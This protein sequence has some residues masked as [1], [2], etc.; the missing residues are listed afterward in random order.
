[1]INRKDPQSLVATMQS[2]YFNF[3]FFDEVVLAVLFVPT[4]APMFN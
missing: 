1:M 4:A 3:T 2:L